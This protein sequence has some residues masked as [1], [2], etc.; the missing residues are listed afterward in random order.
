[1]VDEM[2]FMF[3]TDKDGTPNTTLL[4]QKELMD[5]TVLKMLSYFLVIHFTGIM[6]AS[7]VNKFRAAIG[8]PGDEDVPPELCMTK[9]DLYCF[10]EALGYESLESNTV[11]SGAVF[12]I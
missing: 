4:N 5:V 7:E 3:D 10:Y 2:F 12:S 11:K 1:M 6:I 9:S 8:N